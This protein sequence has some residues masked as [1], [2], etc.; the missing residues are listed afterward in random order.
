[1]GSAFFEKMVYSITVSDKNIQKREE[2]ACG[3][4]QF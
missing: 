3:I 1:L 4:Y 2:K